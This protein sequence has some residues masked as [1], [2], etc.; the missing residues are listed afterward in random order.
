MSDSEE[1]EK[2]NGNGAAA[3]TSVSWP[4]PVD[5]TNILTDSSMESGY[6]VPLFSSFLTPHLHLGFYY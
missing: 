5:N 1:S 4:G 3:G 2:E 6:T